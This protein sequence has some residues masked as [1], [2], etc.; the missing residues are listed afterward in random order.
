LPS[1]AIELAGANSR[2]WPHG[3]AA[4]TPPKICHQPRTLSRKE[5]GKSSEPAA[6]GPLSP[7]K[8][9]VLLRLP[10]REAKVVL[11]KTPFFLPPLSPVLHLPFAVSTSSRHSPFLIQQYLR[12]VST[13]TTFTSLLER[14]HPVASAGKAFARSII[15]TSSRD[16]CCY[17]SPRRLLWEHTA[18][19]VSSIHR[20][21]R[22][23][24]TQSRRVGTVGLSKNQYPKWV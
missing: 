12:F 24:F 9:L 2:D 17:Y 5:R 14:P 21:C 8:S 23:T 20:D 1:L 10:A 16:D 7:Q 6:H 3:S 4:L 19:R 11:L 13:S 22:Q 18:L 15:H